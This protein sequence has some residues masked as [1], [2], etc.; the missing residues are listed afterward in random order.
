MKNAILAIVLSFFL[1]L[2]VFT[3]S[4]L[5]AR[6]D[7]ICYVHCV[8]YKSECKAE[9]HAHCAGSGNPTACAQNIISSVCNQINCNSI[10]GPCPI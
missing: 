7:I 1:G 10:C 3:L 5:P 8:N 2:V 9:A 6:G 4:T